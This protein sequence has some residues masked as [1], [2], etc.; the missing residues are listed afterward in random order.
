M[1]YLQSEAAGGAPVELYRF[2]RK[3]E[4]WT[5]TSGDAPVVHD[6]RTYRPEVIGR[7]SIDASEEDGAGSVDVEMDAGLAIV[8]QFIHGLAPTPVWLVVTR[9]HRGSEDAVVVFRGQVSSM[10]LNNSVATLHCVPT[11]KAVER[12]VPR[13]FYQRMCNHVLYDSFCKADREEH[14][15][16]TVVLQSSGIHMTLDPG[17]GFWKFDIPGYFSAGFVQV[18]D[19]EI[20]SFI[21]THDGPLLTMLSHVS[22]FEVGAQVDVYPGCDRMERT[23]HE[24]FQN[25]ENFLGFPDI[26]TKNPFM[27][28]IL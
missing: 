18:R 27:Q 2:V 11:R 20:R 3:G 25:I 5:Y 6:E 4:E 13:P 9:L 21:V 22:G 12:A 26:P 7:S 23:C 8:P 28:V 10:A 16:E 19:T 24:K 17:M 14:R 1:S 15:V